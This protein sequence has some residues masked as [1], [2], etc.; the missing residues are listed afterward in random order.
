MIHMVFE[1]IAISI[2]LL[3]ILIPAVSIYYVIDKYHDNKITGYYKK[4]KDY[5]KDDEFILDLLLI[6]LSLLPIVFCIFNLITK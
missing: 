1:L 5:L 4:F 3:F 6:A 2:I